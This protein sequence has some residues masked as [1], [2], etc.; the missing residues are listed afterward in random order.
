MRDT[1]HL[2]YC[3]PRERDD[4]STFLSLSDFDRSIF[5]SRARSFVIVVRN[6]GCS[7]QI[8][9]HAYQPSDITTVLDTRTRSR[10]IRASPSRDRIARASGLTRGPSIGMRMPGHASICII[11]PSSCSDRRTY[12]LLLLVHVYH[13]EEYDMRG[14]LFSRKQAG[15]SPPSLAPGDRFSLP[16]A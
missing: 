13:I 7:C 12:R 1:Q 5:P 3:I 11:R 9:S 6:L 4:L 10:S 2:L 15:R 16:R 8:S 14:V